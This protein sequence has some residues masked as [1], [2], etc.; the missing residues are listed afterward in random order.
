MP[1][2]MKK[3]IT[4]KLHEVYIYYMQ[5]YMS[6]NFITK[7]E[8]PSLVYYMFITSFTHI[9]QQ[10]HVLHT[11]YICI[12]LFT[13]VI[14]NDLLYN[15]LAANLFNVQ[16]DVHSRP[17]TWLVACFVPSLG[18]ESRWDECGGNS[19]SVRNTQLMMEYNDCMLRKLAQQIES[20]KEKHFEIKLYN[21]L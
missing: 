7:T 11:L 2:Y 13:S 3:C 14:K 5:Y 16:E 19:K 20:E 4:C 1:H 10:L 8:V 21:V 12:I 6:F 17:S 18:P 9:L 15:L